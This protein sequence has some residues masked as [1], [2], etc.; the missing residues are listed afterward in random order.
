VRKKEHFFWSKGQS[1]AYMVCFGYALNV[2]LTEGGEEGG[3]KD[4]EETGRARGRA[5]TGK[6]GRTPR[7]P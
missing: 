6:R 5:R 1:Q 3:K 2:V 4:G 7:R